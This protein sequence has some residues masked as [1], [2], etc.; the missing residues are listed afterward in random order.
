MDELLEGRCALR[1]WCLVELEEATPVE[2]HH[3]ED[4]AKLDD[5]GECLHILRALHSQYV[6]GDD[7][8]TS[9]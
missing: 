8:V 3:R 4:G 9:R 6:L 5:E 7:H 1:Q 2:A